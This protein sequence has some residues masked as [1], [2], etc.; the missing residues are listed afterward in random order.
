MTHRVSI[1]YDEGVPGSYRGVVIK[2]DHTRRFMT[3]DPQADWA[4]YLA[5]AKSH[6]LM[7]IE[8]SSITHFVF[9]NEEWRFKMESDG[10]E[11]LVPEDRS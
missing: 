7:I 4:S 2:G 10:I 5:H 1:D 8:T 9:D 3:G 6:Q 11:Y